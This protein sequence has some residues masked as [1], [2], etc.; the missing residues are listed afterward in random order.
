MFICSLTWLSNMWTSYT[1]TS[2]NTIFRPWT[3]LRFKVK[4]P[5]CCYLMSALLQHAIY[6]NKIACLKDR[7]FIFESTLNKCL[8]KCF[9]VS[10]LNA[11]YSFNNKVKHLFYERRRMVQRKHK[12]TYTKLHSLFETGCSQWPR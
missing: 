5:V 12:Q 3:I 10:F 7:W 9:L 11:K 6:N 2:L 8:L 1:Q 4:M